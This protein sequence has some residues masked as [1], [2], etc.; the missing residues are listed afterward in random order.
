MV[1]RES[2]SE[3]LDALRGVAILLVLLTHAWT[4]LIGPSPTAFTLTWSGV[5]LFF[6]LSGYL[7]GG[8]L[9]DHRASKNLF[10]V[11]YARRAARILPLYALLLL[12]LAIDGTTMPFWRMITFTLNIPFGNEPPY[13]LAV[14]LTW[15]LAVEEQFYLILPLL[16]RSLPPQR[17][18]VVAIG[19]AA[20]APLWRMAL[21]FL[22]GDPAAGHFLLP[23][24]MDTLFLGVLCAWIVRQPRWRALL[25][26]N[27]VA[28]YAAIAA[29]LAGCA[30]MTWA[31]LT[32][33]SLAMWTIG[34]SWLAVFY[35][36][37]LI[38]A[39]TARPATVWMR[40]ARRPLCLMGLGAYGLYLFH[41][42]LLYRA[43]YFPSMLAPWVYVLALG[44]LTFAMWQGIEQPAIAYTR[45]WCTY[46]ASPPLV[47]V[48]ASLK[49]DVLPGTVLGGE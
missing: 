31:E 5:D 45:K 25:E 21:V 4:P 6:V 8:G 29:G 13:D 43:S 12:M 24:R 41:V 20:S 38:T 36:L 37:I 26:R 19:L 7:I 48:T 11:F 49:G 1:A 40:W 46:K 10:A 28:L 44:G 34:F 27:R 42:P 39:V 2:R 9:I 14:M 22:I 16:I 32:E 33:N 47:A 23:S 18:P 30:V 15:S 35:A 17:L 3:G